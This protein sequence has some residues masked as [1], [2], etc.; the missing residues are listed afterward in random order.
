[1]DESTDLDVLMAR[2]AD[3]DRA[4]FTPVFRAL[5]PSI[6][7]LCVGMLRN[8][9][10]AKDAAQA[11]MEKVL[12]R[13]SSY[14]RARPALPWALAIGAWECR[15]LARQKSRRRE[16]SEEPEGAAV[17]SSFEDAVI[18]EDLTRAAVS[19]M[20]RLSDADK[21]ALLAT[22]WDEAASVRGPT[23]RKRR[24]RALERLRSTFR[25]IYGVD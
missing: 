1:L 22:F 2:L 11:A 14:D 25:R 13:A 4:A 8:E 9:A 12:S 5:W 15:T 3:G 21:E 17:A 23:L 7:K 19:A 10:D 24:E 20:G 18:E 16:V 6:F